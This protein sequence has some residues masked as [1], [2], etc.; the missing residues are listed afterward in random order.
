MMT[1]PKRKIT[2]YQTVAVGV[3]NLNVYNKAIGS[4]LAQGWELHGAPVT[5]E[6][7]I[8]REL[9]KYEPEEPPPVYPQPVLRP[10]DLDLKDC[11]G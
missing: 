2:A 5:S 9:V 10:R 7:V 8:F 3:I 11:G 6:G 1:Y 4:L